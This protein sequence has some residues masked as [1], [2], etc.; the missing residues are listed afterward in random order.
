MSAHSLSERRASRGAIHESGNC[1]TTRNRERAS[2]TYY[3]PAY[4]PKPP[5]P[6]GSHQTTLGECARE[7]SMRSTT[8]FLLLSLLVIAQAHAVKSVTVEQLRAE[9]G[10]FG[11]KSDAKAAEMLYDLQLT[12]RLSANTLAAFEAAVPGPESRRALVALADQ[13]EFLDPPPAE[14]PNQPT[15]SVAQQREVIAKSIDYV[16]DTLN[17]LPNLFANRD[18]ILFEDIPPGLRDESTDTMIPYQPLHPVSRSVETVLYR[19]GQEEI[20]KQSAQPGSS[21]RMAT[22][23]VTSGEFGPIFPMVYGD[24]PKGNLRWSHWERGETGSESVFRFDVSKGASHYR[25]EFCCIRGQLFQ[26]FRAYHGELTLDPAN[27]TILRITLIADPEKGSEIAAAELMVQYEPVELGG[28]KYFCP[29][30]SI[31]LSRTPG[32]IERIA[33]VHRQI[34][35][36]SQATAPDE[37]GDGAPLQTMLNETTFDNYHLF[38]ADTRILSAGNSLGE[39]RPNAPADASPKSLKSPSATPTLQAN[40]ITGSAAPATPIESATAESAAKSE[41]AAPATTPSSAASAEPSAASGPSTATAAVVVETPG[42]VEAKSATPVLATLQPTAPSSMSS[43]PE[44]AVAAPA[45]FPKTPEPLRA[46]SGSSSFSLS[47]NARL[48]DVDLSALGTRGQ[49]ATGLSMKDFEIY[50]N[51]RKQTLRSL[52]RVSGARSPVAQGPATTVSG[53]VYSNRPQA[54]NSLTVQPA[55]MVALASSTIL[56]LDESS[57]SFADL[58]Y[59]RQQVLEFLD[60]LPESEFVGLYVRTGPSFQILAEQTTDHAALSSAL[61]KWVPTAQDL[62][63]AQNEET[64]NR[65]H[66]DQVDSPSDMQY[67][68][69]NVGGM[70][71]PTANSLSAAIINSGGNPASDPKLMKEGQNPQLDALAA[72][73]GVAANLNAI[74]GH[75]N[76]VW[77]ASDNVLANWTDQA[78]GMERG[79]NPIDAMSLG[80]EEVLNDAHVSLYPLNVSQLEAIAADASLENRSVELNPA[81]S[82]EFPYAAGG[83][84][85]N[86]GRQTAEMQQDVRAVQPAIQHLV[87]ATGGRSF[88]RSSNLLNELDSVIADGNATYLLSFS[89]DTPPDGKY[90]RITVTVPAQPGI[91]LRYRTGYLY[92]KEPSSLKDRLTQA[93]WQPQDEN[94]IGLNA[95]WNHASQGAAI[96]LNIASSDIGLVQN[97]DLW[98]DKLDIFLVQRDDTGTRAQAKEQT[99]VLN[100]K[101]KTYQKV[102]RDGIPF[103]EYVEHKQNFGTTRIIVVDENT[104]RM[105]SVTLPVMLER[106]SQ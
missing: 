39:S 53:A 95:H 29:V 68:N 90:H 19:D 62:A 52:S 103:A 44:I 84:S 72:L 30:R 77:V 41:S 59:A 24:L 71:A 104:G 1:P 79:P 67:V 21:N 12:E 14:I 46:A 85:V 69:G 73:I 27:G 51:G 98:T 94:E 63:S 7:V 23:M 50:D 82:S 86:G 88:R 89:P 6:V 8:L 65:Q 66:F 100:L 64:R 42:A 26:E 81:V 87:L 92:S 101:A 93:V 80:V 34:L 32:E 17:R 45:P 57:V 60:R 40:D 55:Q 78:L 33:P 2:L 35:S 97:S 31:S 83:D 22:G 58:N 106:A 28:K 15:L 11:K 16:G 9:V 91:K 96:S 3:R 10:S 25:L 102:L 43:K 54:L 18:T 75:K 36:M 105:G 4:R 5:L 76:L 37:A 20:Q 38:R 47:V 13:A 48:V 61:R 56:L 74:P 49:P 70:D 99:L